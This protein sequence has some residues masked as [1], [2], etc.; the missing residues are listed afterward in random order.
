MEASY[1]PT[2]NPCAQCAPLGAT[3]VYRGIERCFPLL[4]GAQGC[5]TYI[6]R[7]L[8]GHFREPVDIAS[9]SIHEDSVIFGGR[10]NFLTAVENVLQQYRPAVVGVATTC[11]AETIGE[12]VSMF[13]HEYRRRQGGDEGP[14]FVLAP[15]PSYRGTHQ[16]GFLTAIQASLAALVPGEG[17]GG[18]P[19]T[20]YVNVLNTQLLSCEDLR[21]LKELF[22]QAGFTPIVFPDYSESLDGPAWTHYV[23]IPPGGT[24]LFL[25]RRMGS[26]LCTVEMGVFHGDDSPGRMLEDVHGVPLVSTGVPVGVCATDEWIGALERIGTKALSE[27][28][29]QV[30]GRVL[31]TY[32]DGHKYVFGK[33]VM[34]YGEDELVYALARFCME[35][36]MIPAICATGRQTPGFR[37]RLQVLGG[38]R[39][40]LVLSGASFDDM[41]MAAKDA[42]IDLLMGNSKGYKIARGL[43]VPLVR[44]G[45]PIHDRLGGHRI[46]ILGYEGT[47]SLFERVVNALI[48]RE[49]ERSPY[50]YFTM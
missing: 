4:H 1:R 18:H 42:G 47:L 20:P 39:D 6:R 19:R 5:A 24:P 35:V 43:G 50:A 37:E 27:R 30:R 10:D 49:Q 31:D 25:M 34:V 15:T 3:L 23:G 11:L 26:A 45:F 48:E 14:V 36:G 8:V 16:D 46:R 40:I 13:V 41:E 12:D 29:R 7:Y 38:D 44:V 33:R 9:S 17:G 21:F 32:A 22:S 2:V 28:Y